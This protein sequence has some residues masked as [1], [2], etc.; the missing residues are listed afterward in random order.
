MKLKLAIIICI[1]MQFTIG[2]HLNAQEKS[3]YSGVVAESDGSSITGV[4]VVIK[5]TLT[6]TSTDI[7]GYFSIEASEGAVLVFSFLGFEEQEIVLTRNKYL[8]VIM[9]PEYNS[10]EEVV[11]VGYGHLKKADL[12]ASI[13]SV[14]AEDL[15]RTSITSLDQGLQ[16]R[17]AGMVVL[18]TSGQPG[19]GTS[20]RIRGASSIN[21]TNEPLYVIDGIPVMGDDV[22]SGLVHSPSLNPLASINP[23]D[24][25]SIS[26][27]KDASATAIY[28]A[29]GANGVVLITTKRGSKGKI[30]TS[31]N[32]YYGIQQISKTMDMLNAEQLAVLANEAA[33]NAN[34]DRKLIF[35]DLNNL[36]KKSTDW[37]SEIFRS[38]PIQNY[39][40]GFSGGSDK[41]LY[42][43]SVNF[44]SQDG[45]IIG[46]DYKKGGLRLNLDQE[47]SS[48]LKVGTSVNLS[49]NQSNGS[50]TNY[51]GAFASSITS[52]ALEMNPGLPVYNEDGSYVYE[53][54]TS[55]P[56]VGN[57]VQ[58][59]NEFQQLTKNTRGIANLYAELGIL[60]GLNFKTNFGLDFYN[61]KEQSF[62]SKD[63]KRGES[64]EGLASVGTLEGY[65]WIWE[66]TLNYNNTFVEK[67]ALNAVLGMSAQK[68]VD[69]ALA[70]A[71]AEFN[72]GRL[73][74]HSIQS[75]ALKQMSNTSYNA[76]QMLSYLARVNYTFDNRYLFTLTGRIDGSS[77]FGP[78][79][80][81][82]FFPSAAFAWRIS[83][84]QFMN[85]FDNLDNLKLRFSYGKVG[86]EGISAY[87]SQGL[88]L[89]TEA[90]IGDNTIIMG[91]APWTMENQSLKWE[92]TTQYNLGIDISL[93]Q[94]RLSLTAD[95][96][97]KQTE[98]LLLNVPVAF[99]S[100]F[101]SV[102]RNIGSMENK[103]FEISL[104][105]EPIRNKSFYWESNIT[106]GYNKNEIT[107]LANSDKIMGTS[108]L[109][110]SNWTWLEEGL[111][112]GTIYGYKTDGIAQSGENLS[113]IPY[114]PGKTID[115]GDRKYV[116][117]NPDQD[118]ILNE[119]D[120]VVL[121][122][123]NPDFTYGWNNTFSYDL[124]D[125]CGRLNLIIYLQGVSGNEIANFNKFALESFDGT[126][127]NSTAALERWTPGNP[128]DKYP[129]ANAV[130]QTN[131][132]SDHQVEDGSYLRVKDL[133]LAYDLPER[134]L[135][136]LSI[137]SLQI[138]FSGKNVF[139]FTDYSGFD[140]EVSRFGKNNL[141]MGADY[142]SY[143][144]A[145]MYMI[146]LKANF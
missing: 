76:W 52:W 86:N 78:N 68:K 33:D 95:I 22:S 117:Q 29:R 56:A 141:S 138:A 96:Y 136:K 41:S 97:S 132:L 43:L 13:S 11:V 88:L 58:D 146:T 102:M 120:L 31:V 114:F 61:M 81:Y 70:V 111:P 90:Y 24:V 112:I 127:N 104:G 34:I 2:F 124:G 101:D 20:I 116:N 26:V 12:T 27:L 67:H 118:N 39:E 42:F 46:S 19:A 74:Y 38:A 35:A 69:E 23:N 8:S 134:W 103:G 122:N 82:G 107:D 6:G 53:N 110:I 55:N 113:T 119:D 17:A 40:V 71:N 83:E 144:M 30:K 15:V 77:K 7:D 14:K 60:N 98:D 32:M 109:G 72:D 137:P 131:V 92:T 80:K 84:E 100:G 51:E 93:F 126:K 5:N 9:K 106:F 37:Q 3:T 85:R 129:R 28:G 63:I 10:L 130:A 79:N 123:A 1:L 73:G 45:I 50:V 133:T 75:G 115:Y 89:N 44:F 18:N 49:H 25:E 125:R 140:P 94:N 91:Q 66:N 47:L 54:N 87:S 135:E 128:S 64:T 65:N 145:K 62:A 121:G 48:R 16:G 142:G 36:R 108:V 21:G 59:A 139:T 105:L 143:P 4:S 99:H 57:P